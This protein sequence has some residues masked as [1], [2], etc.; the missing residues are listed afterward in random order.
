MTAVR[1]RYSVSYHDK[2]ARFSDHDDAMM[3]ARAQSGPFGPRA[4][5]TEVHDK[6]GI[7]G[8]FFG[9]LPTREFQL[10]WESVLSSVSA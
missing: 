5:I 2:V 8:Q 7:V 6:T 4:A 9:G 10:H 1:T 3:F